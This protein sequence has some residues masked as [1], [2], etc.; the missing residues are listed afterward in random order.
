MTPEEQINPFDQKISRSAVGSL[1]YLI[2]YSRPDIANTVRELSKCMDKTTPAAYKEMT[3]VMR[4]V[5]ATKD[6]GLKI[7][8]HSPDSLCSSEAEY[9]AMAEAVKD[10]KFV[11]HILKC[12]GIKV[13]MPI[14]I[15]VDNVGAIFLAENMNTNSH[16]KH[17]DTRFHFV[18]EFIEE[19]GIKI[20]F[21]KTEDNKADQFTKNVTGDVYDKH[22]EDFVADRK[23]FS[24]ANEQLGRVLQDAVPSH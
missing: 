7:E 4:F 19:G 21:V 3:C 9:Y 15:K 10:V 23:D 2:K 12:I 13:E 1:L 14:T 20:V 18:R 16:T 11:V 8:P 17:I 5:S 6:Y 24:C 22:V